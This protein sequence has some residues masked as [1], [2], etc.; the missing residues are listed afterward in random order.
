MIEALNNGGPN[1]ADVLADLEF[2]FLSNL[3]EE[4]LAD[5]V[6]VFMQVEQAHWFYEDEYV[7]NYKHLKT[8]KMKAFAQ[9][10][11]EQSSVL[12]PIADQCEIYM[13]KFKNYRHQIPCCGAILLNEKCDKML[14]VR[15][16]QGRSWTF[17][18]GKIN[19]GEEEAFCAAREVYE[20]TGYLPT[21][22]AA[23]NPKLEATDHGKKIA[24][25][26]VPGADGVSEFQFAPRAKKEISKIEWFPLNVLPKGHYNVAPFMGRLKKVAASFRKQQ[27]KGQKAKGR[28]KSG[29]NSR[30]GVTKIQQREN[31]VPNGN[32]Q[33]HM[34]TSPTELEPS[35]AAFFGSAPEAALYNTPY[36][37]D[38]YCAEGSDSV[39][40]FFASAAQAEAESQ[41]PQSTD[42][43]SA[44]FAAAKHSEAAP[45]PAPTLQVAQVSLP[46]P[47]TSGGAGV[48]Q[49]DMGSILSSMAAAP[50]KAALVTSSS[51]L[52]IPNLQ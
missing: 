22:D 32:H 19:E 10:L 31:C 17:P 25:F 2:R 18:R 4:E 7:D 29:K 41:P 1:L 47:A 38:D 52:L 35:V 13:N 33:Q 27:A 30:Q 26:V 20:E 45:A 28:N 14:L 11:F 12:S 37:Q 9:I 34:S 43:V 42:S 6:R 8:M 39:S 48:F 50:E 49:F 5:A 44:F 24:L 46:A 15:S 3:P 16:W 21:I 51:G 40:Q 23:S 36:Q